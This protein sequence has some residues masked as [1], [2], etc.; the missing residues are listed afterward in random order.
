LTKTDSYRSIS[1]VMPL[2]SM[3]YLLFGI[4]LVLPAR[5]I[6][7][8]SH[9]GLFAP[10]K[11]KW[12]EAGM[13]RSGVKLTAWESVLRATFRKE[14]HRDPTPAEY[15]FQSAQFN[16]LVPL[17]IKH[18]EITSKG[19]VTPLPSEE[20]DFKGIRISEFSAIHVGKHPIQY[21]EELAGKI[22]CAEEYCFFPDLFLLE[23]NL[24]FDWKTYL[25]FRREGRNAK[26]SV[27]CPRFSNK[28]RRPIQVTL[29]IPYLD[30][31]KIHL[32]F[33][34]LS[35]GVTTFHVNP[36]THYQLAPE[37]SDE[38]AENH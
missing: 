9:R 18:A 6:E 33:V 5:A 31:E 14:L 10:M 15:E 20:D 22:L 8:P 3:I 26:P 25:I 16:E 36:V 7:V 27:R 38:A 2:K 30:R 4:G 28:A 17:L 12:N 23:T 19:Q 32:F 11:V 29:P 1:Q 37:A 24:E 21:P 13:I 35:K 34:N